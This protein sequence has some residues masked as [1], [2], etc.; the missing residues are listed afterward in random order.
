MTVLG[1]TYKPSTPVSEEAF[2]VIVAT[3]LARRGFAVSAYDPAARVVLSGVETAER[4]SDA[5]SG[6][7][8]VI[9]ATPWPEFAMIETGASCR[10]QHSRPRR[11]CCIQ[12]LG[13]DRRTP[14][15]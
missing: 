6:A 14:S 10:C 13:H 9:V 15:A 4:L 7:E 1:L 5:T 8:A 12:V 2:G 3:E 11:G